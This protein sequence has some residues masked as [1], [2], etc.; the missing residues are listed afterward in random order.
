M[1]GYQ[2]AYSIKASQ[3][4]DKDTGKNI[5]ISIVELWSNLKS[6]RLHM[7]HSKCF[8]TFD[9]KMWPLTFTPKQAK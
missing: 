5:P 4:G 8:E 7:Q 3:S 6:F 1:V 9:Q 2:G